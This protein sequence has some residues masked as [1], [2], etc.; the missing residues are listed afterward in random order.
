MKNSLRILVT[1][2]AVAAIPIVEQDSV[3]GEAP[4]QHAQ[5][6]SSP[7]Q[8]IPS[9]DAP[10]SETPF[11][12]PSRSIDVDPFGN[13]TPLLL[14]AQVFAASDDPL[15]T[16]VVAHYR[17][18]GQDNV[19]RLIGLHQ[20]IAQTTEMDDAAP[21]GGKA[22]LLERLDELIDAV[23]AQRFAR[24]S[25]LFWHT[26]LA[27]A[28][29]EAVE[30]RKPVLSLRLEGKLTE[31][32]SC[33]SS[34]WFRILLYA[35]ESVCQTLQEN[36]VLHWYSVRP[37]PKVSID[38]ADGRQIS[39]TLP[40][41]SLHYV[42]DTSG[43]V[44][45][46]LPGLCSPRR[47]QVWLNESQARVAS[48]TARDEA[49]IETSLPPP[50]ADRREPSVQITTDRQAAMSLSDRNHSTNKADSLISAMDGKSDRPS[51]RQG[52]L[53][54][55]LARDELIEDAL[56]EFDQN[57]LDLLA[58]RQPLY[59]REFP[60]AED[61]KKAFAEFVT[62]LRKA[63][64]REEVRN[65]S[66]YQQKI[67]QRLASGVHC[68]PIEFDTWAYEVLFQSPLDD[69]WFRLMPRVRLS[70]LGRNAIRHQANNSAEGVSTMPQGLFDDR[71]QR[72]SNEL[73]GE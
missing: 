37:I 15:D 16:N 26:D 31:E 55:H 28:L 35:N 69:P 46:A 63:V 13:G 29:Q 54:G 12:V 24:R 14:F 10:Q 61:H 6:P 57:S 36:F 32:L 19:T 68:E 21:S 4:Q 33:E 22:H 47:F 2:V 59:G 45:E 1:I 44:I 9:M 7:S 8:G 40:G 65:R 38:F 5:S 62:D 60:T 50:C 27:E 52:H 67:R 30:A 43:R 53:G 58:S 25:G 48:S 56:P 71:L 64:R 72:L 20:Q 34:R 18:G 17:R 41:N 23:A 42:L 51:D 73:F 70:G 49:T 39:T 3:G 66:V 11:S